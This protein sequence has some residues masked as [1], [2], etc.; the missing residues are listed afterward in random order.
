[1]LKR[2]ELKKSSDITSPTLEDV[3]RRVYSVF[4]D[5]FNIVSILC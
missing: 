2:I 4:D 3:N 1:M 5:K